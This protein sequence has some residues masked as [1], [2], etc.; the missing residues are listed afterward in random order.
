MASYVDS[1]R[2][3]ARRLLRSEGGVLYLNKNISESASKLML[4][5]SDNVPSKITFPKFTYIESQE[6]ILDSSGNSFIIGEKEKTEEFCW[7][8]SN[9]SESGEPWADFSKMVL[10][11]AVAGYPGCIGC[12]GPGSDEIWDEASSRI[13]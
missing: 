11:L 9:K 3:A 13:Y 4:Q 8:K 12:G 1:L 2:E 5:I 10:E 7:V 6:I